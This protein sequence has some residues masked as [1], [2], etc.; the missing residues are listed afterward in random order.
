VRLRTIISGGQ[1]GAD[2]G[3]LLAAIACGI[4]HGGW[5]PKGRRSEDGTIPWMFKLTEDTSSDYRSRTKLNIRAADATIIFVRGVPTGGSRLTAETAIKM[6]KPLLKVQIDPK[7]PL[8]CAP[9]IEEFLLRHDPRVINI[10]GSRESK[11]PGIQVAVTSVLSFLIG[12]LLG[13]EI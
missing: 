11:V 9:K 2:Q 13:E 12:V 3:G 6:R 5:C 8:E 4:E 1:T 10:A 7:K